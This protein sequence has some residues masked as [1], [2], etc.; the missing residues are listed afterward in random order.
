[1]ERYAIFVY[2]FCCLNKKKSFFIRIDAL[3]HVVLEGTR[4]LLLMYWPNAD[5]S[6]FILS[7]AIQINNM[8]DLIH[9][10]I[11]I[12]LKEIEF[13]FFL[14]TS[15]T[16]VSQNCTLFSITG[17]DILREF[18]YYVPKC[19]FLSRFHIHSIYHQ[20]SHLLIQPTWSLQTFMTNIT[21]SDME[22]SCLSEYHSSHWNIFD[23]IR[24]DL[25]SMKVTH[26]HFHTKKSFFIS[27]T[28]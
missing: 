14:T 8:F 24:T 17:T 25:H 5:Y 19:F 6:H 12:K 22:R 26:K 16:S 9:N 1:M 20:M 3:V 21:S 27:S 28:G 11:V 18:W 15:F 4:F 7:Q 2:I 10:H 13:R 23:H